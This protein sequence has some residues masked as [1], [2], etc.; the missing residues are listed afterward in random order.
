MMKLETHQDSEISWLLDEVLIC[1]DPNL[2][3]LFWDIGF[4]WFPTPMDDQKAELLCF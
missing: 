2:V 1:F 4:P 3:I